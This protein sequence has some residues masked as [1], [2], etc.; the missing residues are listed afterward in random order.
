M[1]KIRLNKIWLL[2]LLVVPMSNN[3]RLDMASFGAGGNQ[4]GSSNYSMMGNAG[5]LGGKS[6][7][8]SYDL[9]G[10]LAFEET[11]GAPVKP[12]FLN[13]GNYYN[14]LHLIINNTGD[15][16]DAKFAVA[17]SK[18]NFATTQYVKN[19]NT[20]GSSLALTDYQTYSNWIGSTGVYVIGLDA[21]TTYSVKVKAM[22]G[23]FTESQWGAAAT[24]STVNPSLTFDID[25]GASDV[26][27]SAPYQIDMGD[28]IVSTVTNSQQKVWVD[29][30]TN[31]AGGGR[32]Y[33]YGQNGGLYSQITSYTISSG[34]GNLD[35][36]SQGFGLQGVGATQSSG[37]PFVIS[38]PYDSIGGDT[39]GV[40][41]GTIRQIFTSDNVITSGRAS[42]MLKAKSSNDTPSANDYS[43]ILTVIA[44]ANF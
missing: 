38:S 28:L 41:D 30:T 15:P 43:E 14:K 7:G 37:G 44:A 32:V 42:F 9:G 8:A 25:I 35:V 13:D 3:Y 27:S 12:T 24:A 40:E 23:S 19:D 34:N 21:G 20:V 16:S 18:D 5:N 11:V 6:V 17:I 22:Q 2:G 33:V 31:A 39:V 36:L 26:E 10:G 29:F 1:K 4:I